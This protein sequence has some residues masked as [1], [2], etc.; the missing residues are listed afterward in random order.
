MW[1][2]VCLTVI[3]ELVPASLRTTGIGVYFFIIT[4]IGG[5]IQI[6]VPMVQRSLK[7]ALN[8]TEIEAF[9]GKLELN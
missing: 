5:N 1:V 8:L 7:S 9:R 2:G 6:L 3:I 4:N